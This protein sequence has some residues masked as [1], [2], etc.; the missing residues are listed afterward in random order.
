MRLALLVAFLA[1][2]GS[3]VFW[4]CRVNLTGPDPQGLRLDI[5]LSAKSGDASHPLDATAVVTNERAAQIY[6]P[7]GCGGA[8]ILLRVVSP[9][10]AVVHLADPRIASDCP[11]SC[12]V[13][14]EAGG[15]LEHALRF[16]GTL[17]GDD[18]RPY[19]APRGDYAIEASFAASGTSGGAATTVTQQ[20]RFRWGG[21][22]ARLGASLAAKPTR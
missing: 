17:F 1:M 9:G 19:P 6:H 11:D 3:D 18:G 8:G 7:A 22:D 10:G 12:C 14:L 16:D 15:Q 4:S 21:P 5:R 13:P 2:S 20:A